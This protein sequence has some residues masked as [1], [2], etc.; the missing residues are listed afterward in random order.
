MRVARVEGDHDIV[1]AI[2]WRE[3][4]SRA[5]E[6]IDVVGRRRLE[7]HLR[8][9]DIRARVDVEEYSHKGGEQG[10]EE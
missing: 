6:D 5:R 8:V 1:V 10:G 2:V 7:A 3:L 4:R 9:P